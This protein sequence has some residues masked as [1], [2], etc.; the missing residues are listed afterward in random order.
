MTSQKEERMQKLN[1]GWFQITL[2]LML[3]LIF[4]FFSLFFFT[5]KV[6]FDSQECSWSKYNIYSNMTGGMRFFNNCYVPTN[7]VITLTEKCGFLGIS[8]RDVEP[9]RR[10]SGGG[11]CFKLNDGGL[12]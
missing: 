9:Y 11:V 3:M 10:N 2:M 7:S 5:G 6:S 4:I 12:C 1:I 8:C